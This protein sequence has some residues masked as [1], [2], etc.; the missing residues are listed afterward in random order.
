MLFFVLI[1]IVCGHKRRKK[2]TRVSHYNTHW[3][4]LANIT[5]VDHHT[6]RNEEGD[7]DYRCN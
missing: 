1:A 7:N 3:L 5:H 6:S 4:V 2:R